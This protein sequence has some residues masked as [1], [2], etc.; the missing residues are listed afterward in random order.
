MD[1]SPVFNVENLL[2]YIGTFE[3]S[4][5]P[6]SVSTGEASKGAPIM[7]S[8]KYSKEMVDNILNNE[9]VTSK[10]G[11]FRCF[12]VKCHG[13]PDSDATWIQEDDLRLLNPSLLDC[14]LSSHS[15]ESSSLQPRGMIGHGVGIYLVLYE[16]GSSSPMMI[17]IIISYLFNCT[18]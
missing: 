7:P 9:F 3:P 14:Y 17:F 12:L 1:I 16:I 2:P 5:L 11:G 8:F 18:F 4:T 13:R 10:D 6:S 15:L